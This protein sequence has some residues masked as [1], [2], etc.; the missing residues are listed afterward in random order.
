MLIKNKQKLKS[1]AEKLI[2]RETLEGEELEKL[3]NEGVP[4]P[5]PETAKATAKKSATYNARKSKQKKAP[6]LVHQPKLGPAT[7]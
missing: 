4:A 1:I 6:K 3:F 2:T 5:Q 7:P